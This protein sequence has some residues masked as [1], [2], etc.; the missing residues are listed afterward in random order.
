MART[1]N[2]LF[3]FF[4]VSTSGGHKIDPET[5]YETAARERLMSFAWAWL[6]KNSFQAISTTK[7]VFSNATGIYDTYFGRIIASHLWNSVQSEST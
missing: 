5:W 7:F 1:C 3:L 2:A 4:S 6:L